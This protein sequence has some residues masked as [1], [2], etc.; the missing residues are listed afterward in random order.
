M[1]GGQNALL[2]SMLPPLSSCGIPA[3]TA[4][5]KPFLIL[6]ISI[7][8]ARSVR[9]HRV[10]DILIRRDR[11][12]RRESTHEWVCHRSSTSSPDLKRL[13]A[14]WRNQ[15]YVAC[16]IRLP[17]RDRKR[18][19]DAREQR[20]RTQTGPSSTPAQRRPPRLRQ[21]HRT[22]GVC[23][24]LF[25]HSY[26]GLSGGSEK[27]LVSLVRCVA[28]VDIPEGKG[29]EKAD[30]EDGMGTGKRRGDCYRV[31]KAEYVFLS[32]PFP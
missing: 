10:A 18:T 15:D 29:N 16:T 5:R 19:A 17:H 14:T 9:P 13:I 22:R 24:R 31:I 1:L 30:D 2:A 28:R 7:R 11:D 25:A 23:F 20:L 3:C 32:V 12:S 27:R 8:D 26:C 6:P 4:E 21:V